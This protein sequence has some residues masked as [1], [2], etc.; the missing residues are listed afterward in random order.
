VVEHARPRASFPELRPEV[1]PAPVPLTATRRPTFTRKDGTSP[2]SAAS[3]LSRESLFP[4]GTRWGLRWGAACA[5]SSWT[6]VVLR[7]L[8]VFWSW[9]P[10]RVRAETGPPPAPQRHLAAQAGPESPEQ[11]VK[12]ATLVLPS[13][14][15][16]SRQGVAPCCPTAGRVS[17][18]A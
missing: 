8:I 4:E 12:E 15:W 6:V 10:P 13:G 7:S 11:V 18:R 16:S 3:R 2:T 5:L 1:D 17:L 9:K 14:S